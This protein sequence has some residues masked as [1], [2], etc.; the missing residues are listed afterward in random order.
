[1]FAEIARGL[2]I[3]YR[4][5]KKTSSEMLRSNTVE[6]RPPPLV[7]S[8]LSSF[9]ALLKQDLCSLVN[10]FITITVGSSYTHSTPG[11]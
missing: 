10:I 7:H 9:L 5:L 3:S 2:R 6:G 1:M 4:G 8:I 11:I